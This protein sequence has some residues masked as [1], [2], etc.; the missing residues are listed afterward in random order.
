MSSE[1]DRKIVERAD[2]A[3]ELLIT[4]IVIIT[5]LVSQY[6]PIVMTDPQQAA[7]LPT[8]IANLKR[9]SL[10]FFLP[11]IATIAAWL[12]IYFIDN[13]TGKMRLRVFS[14]GPII[15]STILG[16]AEYYAVFCSFL[17]PQWLHFAL[18]IFVV[19]FCLLFPIIPL[20]VL[21][22][23]MQRYKMGLSNVNFFQGGGWLITAKR[24]TPFLASYII[25]W[26]AY[27]LANLA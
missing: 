24:Y 25:F 8:V 4:L 22:K 19:Y 5:G 2:R 27:V 26:S 11:L 7:N 3:F 14:W 1:N 13:E 23:I 17:V 10:V 6:L 18:G 20:L 9:F 21:T 12:V 16:A 15:F